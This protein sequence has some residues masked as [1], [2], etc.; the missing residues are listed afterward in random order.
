[1]KKKLN[2]FWS[3]VIGGFIFPVIVFFLY[4]LTTF[5]QYTLSEFIKY[6][7]ALQVYTKILAMTVL[8][9]LF[10]FFIFM[11][12]NYLKATRGVLIITIIFALLIIYL[13]IF[14]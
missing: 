10:L 2:N 8:P 4:Y 7:I 5:S 12:L 6:A 14:S 13:K 11:W 3:G 1:M 9:N